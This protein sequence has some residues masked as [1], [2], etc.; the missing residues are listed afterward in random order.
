MN[1]DFLSYVWQYSLYKSTARLTS[2]QDFYVEF[3]GVR[4]HDSGPDYQNARIRIDD[5]LWVGNVEIHVKS[6]DW[7]IHGHQNDAAYDNV[8]L[9][10]VYDHDSPVCL[11]IDDFLPVFE[12]KAFMDE[13][14][15]SR[16][17]QFMSSDTAIPCKK[18]IHLRDKA[19]TDLWMDSLAI[20]RFIR[21]AQ[22][23]RRI[24]INTKNDWLQ[25]F[26][27]ITA[28]SFGMKINDDAME[29]LA[30]RL[31]LKLL[32]PYTDHLDQLEALLFGTSGILPFKEKKS[33]TY[34]QKLKSE[35]RHLSI[36]HEI[37]ALSP[38]IWKFMRTRPSNFPTVRL[39]QLA[40][41]ISDLPVLF[42]TLTEESAE[43]IICSFPEIKHSIYWNDHSQFGAMKSTKKRAGTKQ[44]LN[45]VKINSIIPFMMLYGEETGTSEMKTKALDLAKKISPEMNHIIRKWNN[46]GLYPQNAA[47]SQ[48]LLE[49]YN[50]YCRIKACLRCRIGHTILN[51]KYTIL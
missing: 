24:L 5:T 39:S 7:Y 44:L 12:M 17:L 8:I 42:K 31:H 22:G 1:E 30:H 29:M 46:F 36:K 26:F 28:R 15:Y 3:P 34:C 9:H 37:E 19:R 35:Y 47:E 6:S 33:D 18:L 43:N 4:N 2:L 51:Q 38:A 10:V 21:K 23:Y 40:S 49:L 25:S 11:K 45:S 48:A 13:L 20:S 32:L 14:L 50:E 16:Y 27:V 41:M